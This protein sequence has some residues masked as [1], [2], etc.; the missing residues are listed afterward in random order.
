MVAVPGVEK[1]RFHVCLQEAAC[2]REE[3]RADINRKRHSNLTAGNSKAE[4]LETISGRHFRQSRQEM[5][6][7]RPA[8]YTGSDKK[9][10][11]LTS[12]Q[13]YRT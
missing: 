6:E 11:A 2:K 13:N 7:Y 3:A 4:S 1:E 5:S 8:E 12:A 9:L 10:P